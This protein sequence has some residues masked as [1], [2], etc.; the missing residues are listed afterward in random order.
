VDDL[1]HPETEQPDLEE[2]RRQY[3]E[4]AVPETA[5]LR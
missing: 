1:E 4:A 5:T 3:E 2:L